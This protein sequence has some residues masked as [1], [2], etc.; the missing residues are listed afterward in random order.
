[1]KKLKLLQNSVGH[2]R[3]LI[4]EE[5]HGQKLRDDLQSWLLESGWKDRLSLSVEK[6]TKNDHVEFIPG[7]FQ[8]NG[9][10]KISLSSNPSMTDIKGPLT[11]WLFEII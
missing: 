7:E 10:Q 4:K 6:A 8:S 1:M 9:R 11:K 5:S 3:I 2:I